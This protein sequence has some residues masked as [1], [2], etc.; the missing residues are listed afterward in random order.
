MGFGEYLDRLFQWVI[1]DVEHEEAGVLKH[2]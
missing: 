2:H 1:A